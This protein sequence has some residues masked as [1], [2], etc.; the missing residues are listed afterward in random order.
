M[1]NQLLIAVLLFVCG[2]TVIA[3]KQHPLRSLFDSLVCTV[4]IQNHQFV[5]I[6]PDIA[7]QLKAKNG[8]PA[9]LDIRI[10]EADL[11]LE[12]EDLPAKET[13]FDVTMSI[14]M[15][16]G[17]ILNA[18]PEF[19]REQAGLKKSKLKNWPDATE[20]FQHPGVSYTLLINRSQMGIVNCEAIRPAFSLKQKIPYYS[21]AGVSLAL[22]GLGQVYRVQK[23]EYYQT[24]QQAWAEGSPKQSAEDDPRQKALKSRKAFQICTWTGI[25][26]LA[27][28]ATIFINKRLKIKRKQQV[29]D[30][31][32]QP[33]TIQIKSSGPGIG[34]ML[35][36]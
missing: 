9:I 24:Y 15:P 14:R 23:N 19:V 35:K 33:P 4:Q 31:F 25:G 21:T 3:Q 32:C 22:I 30:Q 8:F 18:P 27:L 36:F 26:L 5:L 6:K 13:W 34:L 10:E 29:Y 28:D 2:T 7:T 20:Y 1:K 12:Y 16:D 11:I 17:Q